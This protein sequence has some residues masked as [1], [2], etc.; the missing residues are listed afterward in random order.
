[1]SRSAGKP[2]AARGSLEGIVETQRNC[3]TKLVFLQRQQ[4][5]YSLQGLAHWKL[6][7]EPSI[8]AKKPTAV[9]LLLCVQVGL[10]W[11]PRAPRALCSIGNSCLSAA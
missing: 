4:E 6:R 10:V 7:L 3:F 1:M 11:L 5:A 8:Q 2:V 9:C